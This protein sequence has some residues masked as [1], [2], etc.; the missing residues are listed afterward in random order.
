MASTQI[1]WNNGTNGNRQIWTW[2]FWVKRSKL[3]TEQCVWTTRY[4]GSNN[5]L[6]RFNANDTFTFK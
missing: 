4:N 5:H 1:T 3:G 6:F 2:S